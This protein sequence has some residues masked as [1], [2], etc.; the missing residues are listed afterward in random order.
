[1]LE[2]RQISKHYQEKN[3]PLLQL[4]NHLNL[5]VQEGQIVAILGPSGCGKSTLLKMI[6]GLEPLEQGQILWNGKDISQLAPER[7]HFAM[8]FQ[9]FAL[10]PHLTVQDNVAFGLVERGLPKK[11]ARQQALEMLERFGLAKFYKSSTVSLS[12]GEQ[13]RVALVR[14]LITQPLLLLLD[15]PFSALDF[16]LKQSLRQEFAQIIQ[17]H[18]ISTIL[19]THD[20][21]EAQILAHQAYQLENGQL[22]LLWQ[23]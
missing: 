5:Q 19:V 23:K 3:G 11:Q 16:E 13:Q 22:H 12:G 20:P 4:A 18:Q 15:E 1:M 14:A 6:A 21:L 10:F 2:L 7:R 17:A 8:M 9:D